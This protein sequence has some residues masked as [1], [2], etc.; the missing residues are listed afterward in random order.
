VGGG[1]MLMLDERAA[2]WRL[3]PPERGV[4]IGVRRYCRLRNDCGM[5][6]RWR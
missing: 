4:R 6:I 1:C 5:E 3:L 2:W